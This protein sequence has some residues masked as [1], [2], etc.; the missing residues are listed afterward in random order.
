MAVKPARGIQ[1]VQ[2]VNKH[3]GTIQNRYRVRINRKDLQV[4]RLFDDLKEAE[5]FLALSSVKKGKEIIFSITEEERK[6][7]VEEEARAYQELLTN[8]PLAVY[9]KKYIDSYVLTRPQETYLQKRNIYN[10]QSF[11]RLIQNT[12]VEYHDSPIAFSS[13]D[14]LLN[15]MTPGK[16]AKLGQVPLAKIDYIV[17]NNY[18]RKRLSLGKKKISVAREISL[19]SKFFTKLKHINPA[20][21]DFPNPC[22]AYDRELLSNQLTKREFRM[23]EAEEKKL[24]EALDNTKNPQMK[25]IV[26]LSLYTAMRRSEII[27]LTWEQLRGNY[28]QLI[29]T[30]SGKPRKVWLIPEAKEV[31]ARVA[32][33]END[34]RLFTYSITGFEGSFAKLKERIGLKHVRFHDMRREAI[35]RMIEKVGEKNSILLTEILGLSSVRKFQESYLSQVAS[36][37]ESEEAIMK[38]VGHSVEEETKGYFNLP[39]NL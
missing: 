20:L 19:L 21:R 33:R 23:S 26:L 7:K 6:K 27:T 37:L 9:L 18:I 31:L 28:V 24:M 34:P 10:L 32:K 12:E 25:Q 3:T 36:P 5:E 14:S 38:S 13:T 30:K 2:W 4:D 39:Q 17:I 35:S 15:L 29:H 16:K 22:L 11:Y 8:P 1:L